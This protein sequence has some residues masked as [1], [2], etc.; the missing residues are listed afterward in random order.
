MNMCGF[1]PAITPGCQIRKPKDVRRGE[2]NGRKIVQCGLEYFEKKNP[3]QVMFEVL[4][5][6][7]EIMQSLHNFHAPKCRFPIF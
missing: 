5:N 3:E 4:L 1:T 6:I 2:K 7:I